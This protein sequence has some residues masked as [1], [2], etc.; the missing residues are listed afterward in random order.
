MSSETARE[1]ATQTYETARAA[2][3]RE[4]NDSH[5]AWLSEASADADARIWSLAERC[6]EF[7][8][9]DLK[10]YAC[11]VQG[12]ALPKSEQ[13]D[14]LEQHLDDLAAQTHRRK[15][16]PGVVELSEVAVIPPTVED[17]W[18]T[19][20]QYAAF[21]LHQRLEPW[22]WGNASEPAVAEL[23]PARGK[24]GP[25]PKT[26]EY[27]RVV[28]VIKRVVGGDNWVDRIEDICSALDSDQIPPPPKWKGQGY[29]TWLERLR[30][31]RHVVIEVLRYRMESH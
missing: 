10:A 5:T 26:E 25:K 2:A 19:V 7:L 27:A 31:D 17:D 12:L 14:Q 21:F 13:V 8:W 11:Y 1:K 4:F 28:E 9:H 29:D 18:R 22:I 15:W 16:L 20:A 24:R 30:S 3:E 23:R 6:A